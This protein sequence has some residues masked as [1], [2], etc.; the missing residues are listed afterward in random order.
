MKKKNLN[1]ERG[2]CLQGVIFIFGKMASNYGFACKN[3]SLIT[4]LS[5]EHG[6]LRRE[7][8][9]IDK[10]D[11]QRALKYGTFENTLDGRCWKVEYDGITFIT[12]PKMTREITAFPSPLP[13]VEVD[14]KAIEATDKLK[15]LLEQRPELFTTHTVVVI[16]NSGSMLS[17][18]NDVHLYRNSQNAAFSMTALEL[19]AEQL[20]SNTA[21]NSDLVSLVKFAEHP[22]IEFSREPVH[23]SVYNKF[24]EHRNTQPYKNRQDAALWDECK[25]GSNYL[26]ALEKVHQL[27]NLGHHDKL[28]LSIFFFSDGRSTDHMKLGVSIEESYKLMKEAITAIASRFGDALTVSMVG[29]GDINDQFEPLKAMANAAMASG[30]KGSFERCEKTANS[31]SS[32]ISSMVT[33]TLKSSVALRDGGSRGYTERSDLTSGNKSFAIWPKW[34]YFKILGHMVYYPPTKRFEHVTS[35]PRAASHSPTPWKPLEKECASTIPSLK[36]QIYWD[37]CRACSVP[38]LSFRCRKY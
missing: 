22:S 2:T 26:P 30:A 18:K 16:D 23:W 17:K 19:I 1:S 3:T 7:Q 6:R 35:L 34:N 32:S 10:R 29:L 28:A 5:S 13:E 33:S 15:R 31:I 38:L 36:F 25:G 37:G 9:D 24:L 27:L 20:F 12:N 14:F 8:R 21:G 4:I 11:L